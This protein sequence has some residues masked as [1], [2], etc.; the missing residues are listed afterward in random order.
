MWTSHLRNSAADPKLLCAIFLGCT[1]ANARVE[2]DFTHIRCVCCCLCSQDT[3]VADRHSCG[4]FVTTAWDL[5]WG[6]RQGFLVL[7]GFCLMFFSIQVLQFSC[8][9]TMQATLI[10]PAFLPKMCLLPHVVSLLT[11]FLEFLARLVRNHA[12]RQASTA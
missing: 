10:V 12:S 3:E 2:Q 8:G 11:C 6:L 4:W 5:Q 1:L 7:S 9:D